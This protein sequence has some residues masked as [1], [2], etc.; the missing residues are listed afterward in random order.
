MPYGDT[1]IHGVSLIVGG[2][3]QS[4]FGSSV[5][6]GAS[7][8][9][10]VSASLAS[11]APQAGILTLTIASVN[12]EGDTYTLQSQKSANPG[13]GVTFSVGVIPL[14]LVGH[15]TAA[16]SLTSNV[17]GTPGITTVNAFWD[18]S[19]PEAIELQPGGSYLIQVTTSNLSTSGGQPVQATLDTHVEVWWD[20]MQPPGYYQG[21]TSRNII[22]AGG[23][24][25]NGYRWSIPAGWAGTS[26]TIY[27]SVLDP[28]GNELARASLPFYVK[29]G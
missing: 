8:S 23:S 16:C 13:E 14:N 24:K 18:V 9:F 20:G 28:N 3:S 5:P 11:D 4:A 15:W 21:W 29:E 6:Y 2:Q 1:G 22:A 27:V 17:Q 12:P 7:I 26:G 10:R 25:V 19:Q